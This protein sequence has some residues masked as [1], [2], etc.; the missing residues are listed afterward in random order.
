[1]Y[2]P[3]RV[4][5]SAA[6]D[7]IA[8]GKMVGHGADA[9]S[10]LGS[11]IQQMQDGLMSLDAKATSGNTHDMSILHLVGVGGL[12]TPE[13]EATLLALHERSVKESGAGFCVTARKY[14][15]KYKWDDVT[16]TRVPDGD[17]KDVPNAGQTA[18]EDA[19]ETHDHVMVEFLLKCGACPSAS[20][21]SGYSLFAFAS[22][23]NANT[24]DRECHLP[25]ILALLVAHGHVV[26]TVD[27]QLVRYHNERLVIGL[28]PY[29]PYINVRTAAWGECM[30]CALLLVVHH[31]RGS[32]YSCARVHATEAYKGSQRPFA[33]SVGS[34][35]RQTRPFCLHCGHRHDCRRTSQFCG[36]RPPGVSE[37]PAATGGAQTIQRGH[38]CR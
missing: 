35:W 1:M 36:G 3:S 7:T 24:R 2:S 18:M 4:I 37:C 13:V 38:A 11:L 15:Q 33:G 17:S 25:T 21:L 14:K 5:P 10:A 23:L 20:T 29:A 6:A 30:W 34:S 26:T 22:L 19:I 31:A 28:G 8:R 9:K 16:G 12:L 27:L 32:V